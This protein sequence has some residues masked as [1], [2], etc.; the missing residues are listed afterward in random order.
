MRLEHLSRADSNQRY[1]EMD[2]ETFKTLRMIAIISAVIIMFATIFKFREDYVRIPSNQISGLSSLSLEA[3]L[4]V[5]LGSPF[6]GVILYYLF[7]KLFMS[8]W[9]EEK[10][11]STAC[12]ML[13][14]LSLPYVSCREALKPWQMIV[15][16]ISAMLLV[17]TPL[18]LTCAFSSDVGLMGSMFFIILMTA[19]DVVAVIY[20][21][22]L[23][24]VKKSEYICM[25]YYIFQMSVYRQ[26]SVIQM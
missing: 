17:Q 2:V 18:Y 24:L 22:Y 19:H 5:Y 4:I 6:V 3:Q 1:K 9:C 10:S 26:G 20:I 8:I 21:L 15:S 7:V 11:Y 13:S 23:W 12:K 14:E 25:H 16:Y